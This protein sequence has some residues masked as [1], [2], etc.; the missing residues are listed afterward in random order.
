MK[1]I[2]T[3]LSAYADGELDRTTAREVEQIIATDPAA[4][5][6]VAMHREI[7]ALLHAACT[8]RVF[9]AGN[10]PLA[11]APPRRTVVNRR[12]GW[13][14]AA[15]IAV[16]VIGFGGGA[17]W[18]G[19]HPSARE[20]A[21]DEVAEYHEV[22]SRETVHLVETPASQADHIKAWLGQRME[23]TI[24]IPDLSAAGLQ[25]AGARMLVI[26]RRPVANLIYTR[27]NGLPI[28]F[29]ILYLDGNPSSLRLDRRGGLSLAS[30]GNGT[31]GFVVVGEVETG[32]MRDIAERVLD[33][34]SG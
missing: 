31:Y 2:D 20:H 8:E 32:A 11:L 27:A 28:A 12:F 23:R 5:R 26:D 7:S 16:G 6:Q 21:L 17:V 3:L 14:I 10:L 13:A 22:F 18:S 34:I 15:S 33:Q 4:R 9:S 1:D 24:E 25:F 19:G 30:W 29:C